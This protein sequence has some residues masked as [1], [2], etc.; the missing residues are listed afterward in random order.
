MTPGTMT[1]G[2]VSGSRWTPALILLLVAVIVLLFWL[3]VAERGRQPATFVAAVDGE[4][5]EPLYRWRMV[6]SWPRGFP[7]LGT[8]PE[9]FA[10]N[11]AQMSNGRIQIRV[12]GAGELV[13]AMGVFDAVS[14]GTVEMGHSG[15]YYWRGKVP[16]S[17]FFTTLPFGMTAQEMN[18]WLYYGGGMQLWRELYEPFDL[19][20]LAAGN[21]G[22]QMFGWF[23][24]PIE[25]A[26]DLRRLRVRLPGMAG[27]VLT[28]AGGTAVNLPG[29]E[30]YTSL[31]TGVVDAVEWV[32]PYNDMA[33]GLHEV[34]RYYYYPGWHEP[35]STLEL[36][37]NRRVFEQLPP[38]LRA[39]VEIAAREAN[40]DMLDE[41]TA[42]NS[43]ALQDLLRNHPRV[44]LREL[45][46]DVLAALRRASDDALRE[47][48]EGDPASRRVYASWRAFA[49]KVWPYHRISEQAY[50]NAREQAPPPGSHNSEPESVDPGSRAP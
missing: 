30:L 13:P 20:P 11:V 38:D 35:G 33:L 1:P 45:P 32:G 25:S 46:E 43:S 10:R 49:D 9:R 5:Q 27:E 4:L 21:T 36:I 37:I 42:R 16:A 19:V 14:L 29:G 47:L 41:Y 12:Y 24:R 50:I 39:I 2:A 40:Q 6:T 28:R 34:A 26:A 44:Q 3:Y 8:A 31:Q 15:A 22:V 18:A 17:Q 7:G 23:N 48:V